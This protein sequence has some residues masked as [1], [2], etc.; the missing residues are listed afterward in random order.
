MEELRFYFRGELYRVDGQGRINANGIG[1]FSDNWRFLGGSTHPWHNH[2]TVPFL[3]AFTYPV[4]LNG[5]IGWDKD[6]GTTRSWGGRYNGRIPR[7]TGA[8][9]VK[10]SVTPSQPRTGVR[11]MTKITH[12]YKAVILTKYLVPTNFRGSRVKASAGDKRTITI[13]W[14]DALGIE[15]NHAAGALALCAKFGWEGTLIGGGTDPGYAF[16]FTERS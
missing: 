15:E 14:D 6:H 4:F 10:R 5:C 1:E 12:S 11:T 7:I 9:L 13:G 2:V 16:I 3:T 8:H